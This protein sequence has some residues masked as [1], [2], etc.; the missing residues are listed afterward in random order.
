MSSM[1]LK[2]QNF[3]LSLWDPDQDNLIHIPQWYYKVNWWG[4][5]GNISS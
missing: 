3:E 1:C 4:V 2:I 5:W